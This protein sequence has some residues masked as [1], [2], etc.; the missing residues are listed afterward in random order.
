MIYSY[1]CENP[2]CRL[3]IR[4]A[5]FEKHY[6][7]KEVMPITSCPE[8]G[9]FSRRDYAEIKTSQINANR[10]VDSPEVKYGMAF[11]EKD[12]VEVLKRHDAEYQ[13]SRVPRKKKTETDEQFHRRLQNAKTP[14]PVDLNSAAFDRMSEN[15]FKSAL[16][17]AG[18]NSA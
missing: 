18:V 13:A 1:R 15:N 6:S 5:S 9:N 2:A 7:M 12:R 8:C 4:M 16:R 17:D 10:I 3:G 11:S 14:E